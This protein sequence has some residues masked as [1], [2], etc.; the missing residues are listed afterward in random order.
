M[1][2]SVK[3]KCAICVLI[4]FLT[5]HPSLDVWKALCYYDS[6]QFTTKSE[7]EIN[8]EINLLLDSECQMTPPLA[9]VVIT[10]PE[11]LARKVLPVFDME[12]LTSPTTKLMYENSKKASSIEVRMVGRY[13]GKIVTLDP[14]LYSSLLSF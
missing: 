6:L 3:I 2:I 13:Q 9:I 4:N 10:T 11:C 14:V 5:A 8:E 7:S 12:S 1:K